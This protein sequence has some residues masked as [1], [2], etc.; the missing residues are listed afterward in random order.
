MQNR[1]ILTIFF[2]FAISSISFAQNLILSK[3]ASQIIS[4]EENPSTGYQWI[5]HLIAPSKSDVIV[6]EDLGF[7]RKDILP[8]RP[9][10]HKWRL[11]ARNSGRVILK[12]LYKRSWE[13]EV[14]KMIRINILVK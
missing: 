1:L 7:Y 14:V 12:L 3:G 10:L 6:I 8:G 4:L 2:F 9:G 5:T 11:L 13:A